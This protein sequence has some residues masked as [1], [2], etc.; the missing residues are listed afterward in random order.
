MIGIE[1][2]GKGIRVVDDKHIIRVSL[3][4]GKKALL[5]FRERKPKNPNTVELGVD[6]FV[7]SKGKVEKKAKYTVASS[8][9]NDFDALVEDVGVQLSMVEKEGIDSRCWEGS[10]AE[11]IKNKLIRRK[12][13]R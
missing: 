8:L 6:C 5:Q 3:E 4:N 1:K 12:G 9:P 13:T 7:L 2:I 11:Q 10:F